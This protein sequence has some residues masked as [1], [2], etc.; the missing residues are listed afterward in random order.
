[1]FTGIDPHW[2]AIPSLRCSWS[3]QEVELE[4][5]RQHSIFDW[6]LKLDFDTSTLAYH[7]L[8]SDS[9]PIANLGLRISTP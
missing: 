2:F 5:C 3:R 6:H 8:R 7:T 4:P 1:M 9:A